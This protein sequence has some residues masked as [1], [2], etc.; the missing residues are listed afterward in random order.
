M[1]DAKA[2]AGLGLTFVGALAVAYGLLLQAMSIGFDGPSDLSRGAAVRWIA[3]MSFLLVGGTGASVVAGTWLS[4]RL[5][6]ALLA[7][8]PGAALAVW[9]YLRGVQDVL[10]KFS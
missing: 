8:S 1:L 10:S 5:F 9:M 6:L 7:A 3:L 2:M 4:G